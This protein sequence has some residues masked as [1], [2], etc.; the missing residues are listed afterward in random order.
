M[1][2]VKRLTFRGWISALLIG[3]AVLMS[4]FSIA[5]PTLA[6]AQ[7]SSIRTWS[8]RKLFAP[9]K[10]ERLEPRADVQRSARPKARTKKSVKSRGSAIARQRA[11]P[12]APVVEKQPDAKVVL[13]VG[14][15]LGGGLAE[16]LTAVYAENPRIRIVDKSNGS[17]GLVREDFYNWPQEI[18]PLI[19]AEKPAAIVVMLGSNDRQQLRV[20]GASEAPRT[21][22]WTKEYD[23]RTKA[24]ATAIRQHKVPLL[25]VG[26][27]A[28]KSSKMT[29]DMLAFN[30]VYR[31][32]AESVQGEFVDVWDGF[33]DEN[34]SFV[35]VGPDINGQPVRLRSDDGINLTRAG[36]RKLAFY[37][38]KPLN[39]M[40]GETTS[41]NAAATAPA[42]LPALA[43]DGGGVPAPIDRTVPISLNDPE[44][45]GGTELLGA[46]PSADIAARSPTDRLTID[47]LAP[48]A[49]PGRADDFSWPRRTASPATTAAP[50]TPE[51]TATINR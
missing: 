46:R 1:P 39:K 44:L 13:V 12:E 16:G 7:E 51:T 48:E 23:R 29:S 26:I 50:T 15:F 27:P 9:R 11:E 5:A 40:L 43:P 42:A 19:E 36:K 45:D 6:Y 47:G 10:Q 14:D 37:A 34:G 28:F 31:T 17:S 49:A 21:D 25:W 20:D 2:A 24:F 41:P 22:K 8:L 30:E 3:L 32:S 35:T 38:E 33:V 18:G 4:G